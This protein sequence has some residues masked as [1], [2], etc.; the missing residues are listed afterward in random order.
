[1][2]MSED[3][4]KACVGFRR[5]DTLR[6]QFSTLYQPSVKIDYT[7]ADAVLDEGHFATLKKKPRN[8]DPVR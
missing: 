3:F 1:M 5:V 7:P 2:S 8:T 4:V 6:R